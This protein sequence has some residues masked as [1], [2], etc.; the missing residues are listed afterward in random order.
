MEVSLPLLKRSHRST[1][2]WHAGSG[3][4]KSWALPRGYSG[5]LAEHSLD[6]AL[7]PPS[8]RHMEIDA[9]N[10]VLLRFTASTL[11][12][13]SGHGSASLMSE[14]TCITSCISIE[15]VTNR[16]NPLGSISHTLHKKL[17]RGPLCKSR[18]RVITAVV[19]LPIAFTVQ[20]SRGFRMLLSLVDWL[21]SRRDSFHFMATIVLARF[22][23]FV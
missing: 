13:L 3:S 22:G 15:E 7:V 9:P 21:I 20:L 2:G 18:I 1:S 12:L 11:D 16:L 8:R 4:K 5:G 17:F 10:A 19:N 23:L 14:N 6:A